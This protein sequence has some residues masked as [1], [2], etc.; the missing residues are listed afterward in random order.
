M[1]NTTEINLSIIGMTCASCVARVENALLKLPNVD[2]AQVNL[3]TNT[4]KITAKQGQSVDAGQLIA[5]VEKIGYDANLVTESDQSLSELSEKHSQNNAFSWRNFGNNIVNNPSFRAGLALLLAVPFLIEMAAD[6]SC[7]VFPQI[8]YCNAGSGMFLPISLQII[9]STIILFGLGFG[10]LASAWR[11]LRHATA[12]MDSLVSLGSLTAWFYSIALI[13]SNAGRSHDETA[14]YF[15]GVGLLIA[16]VLLGRALEHRARHQAGDAIAALRQLQPLV[17]RVR[18]DGVEVTLPIDQVRH[19]DIMLIRAG[20]RIAADGVIT[21]GIAAIDESLITGES[22]P[23]TR[24]IGDKV[25]AGSLNQDGFLAI[26]VT[27]MGQDSMIANLIKQVADAQASKPIW[28]KQV[29]RIAAWFVPMILILSGIC[30]AAWGL[31]TGDLAL[32]MR[33]AIGVL[34]IAC[35]CALGLATPVAMMVGVGLAAKRGILIRDAD[36]LEQCRKIDCVLFDKTGTLSMGKPRVTDFILFNDASVPISALSLM[37]GLQ[38]G[39]GHPLADAARQ[40]AHDPQNQA[41]F[42]AVDSL[43]LIETVAHAGAGVTGALNGKIYGFGNERLLSRHEIKLDGETQ[44]GV[45]ES[46]N[47]ADWRKLAQSRGETISYLAELSP[48]PR[49]LA[50]M[51][52]ADSPRPSAPAAIAQLRAQGVTT[53]ILSGD[54]LA[55]TQEFARQVGVDEYEGNLPPEGKLQIMTKLRQSGRV[56]AMVGD[57]INDAPALAA[58]NLGIAMGSGTDVAMKSATLVLMRPDP[59]L[60]PESLAL[61]RRINGKIRQGLIWAFAYNVVGIPLAA[62]GY[63]SPQLAAAAMAASSIAVVVNALS[64]R[65]G[66]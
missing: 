35:P 57:G 66:R 51:S 28:Q 10:I 11:A 15:E 4:A 63:L 46:G 16:F 31:L 40:F 20:E 64:L 56:I 58:A 2:K 33:A 1:E 3:M 49:I 17:A 12:N 22:L 14:L 42:G 9:L 7:R 53:M 19:Q 39:S 27:A 45:S 52:F 24:Q 25:M 29:D 59:I 48:I 8:F 21:E 47:L 50:A 44:T 26:R 60:V 30:F 38:Q 36:G 61:A 6:P 37:A 18:R 32:A 23:V 34:V 54:N 5:S 62:M 41:K 43:T 65:W 13:S 55:A